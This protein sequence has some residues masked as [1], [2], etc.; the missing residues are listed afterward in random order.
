M[1][2]GD[3]VYEHEEHGEG[4]AGIEFSE[5]C[6]NREDEEIGDTVLI[7]DQEG[8]L[9]EESYEIRDEE[10]DETP[11]GVETD[12]AEHPTLVEEEKAE[13]K[14]D[15]MVV[16]DEWDHEDVDSLVSEDGQF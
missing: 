11:V 10:E 4:D 1:D 3:D 14:D 9:I 12:D 6:E 16:V 2:A 5:S 8:D 13:G 7:D 15:N